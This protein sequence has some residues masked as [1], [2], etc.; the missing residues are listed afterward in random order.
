M[1]LEEIISELP[2]GYTL[3]DV[4]YEDDLLKTLDLDLSFK[5][6]DI[7]KF[8][9]D[10]EKIRNL[11]RR[12][13]PK[14]SGIDVDFEYD[15][16][17]SYYEVDK[18]AIQ[19]IYLN[20]Y[21]GD[22]YLDILPKE[23]ILDILMDMDKDEVGEMSN[24][25]FYISDIL[26]DD[27]VL[28]RLIDKELPKLYIFQSKNIYNYLNLYNDILLTPEY[29][30]ISWM[31]NFNFVRTPTLLEYII[32]EGLFKDRLSALITAIELES[33]ELM[34]IIL[35]TNPLD[36]FSSSEQ[37]FEKIIKSNN[38]KEILYTFLDYSGEVELLTPML[39]VILSSYTSEDK[40][41]YIL[42]LMLNHP[43]FQKKLDK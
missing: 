25:S 31:T 38:V 12:K 9:A 2:E 42:S 10:V 41:L 1:E 13:V 28:K 11:F 7:P 27:Y 5:V 26:H 3:S 15:Y 18:Y 29:V 16:Y 43:T 6:S 37:I 35:K 17:S 23:L 32:K 20:F 22:I 34:E 39:R 4:Q 24:V 40:K 36:K 14:V 21:Y 19:N 30:D 33:I 8:D